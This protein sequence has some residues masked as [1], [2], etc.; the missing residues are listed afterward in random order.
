MILRL[1]LP[2]SALNTGMDRH[3]VS[4]RCRRD[5][6]V[7]GLLVRDGRRPTIRKSRCPTAPPK[8]YAKTSLGGGEGAKIETV[9]R[10]KEGD[11]GGFTWA[12]VDLG[13]KAYEIGI[14]EDAHSAK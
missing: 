5:N 10:E 12:E 2:S 4:V 13:G 7:L 11:L 14:L 3:A 1:E 8:Q 9:T 6:R